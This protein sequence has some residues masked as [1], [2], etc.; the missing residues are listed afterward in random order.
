[1]SL[2]KVSVERLERVMPHP[3]ADR[4]E[5]ASCAGMSFQ[6]VVL[7]GKHEVGDEVL[8]FP[9]D[10]LLPLTTVETLGLT[11][12]LTGQEQNRIKTAKLRGEISQG[13]VEFPEKLLGPSWREIPADELTERLGVTKY[14]AEPISCQN[15]TLLPLPDGVSVYD[16]EGA[17]RFPEVIEELLDQ[18][19]LITEKLEGSHFAL[20]RKVDGTVLVCQ[21]RYSIEPEDGGEH[22][23]WRVA[24][25]QGLIDF[26]ETLTKDYAGQ[27]ITLRGEFIGPKVQKNIYQL[28]KQAVYLFDILVDGRYLDGETYLNVTEGQLRAPILSSDSSL[29]EWLAAKTIQEASNG[30]SVLHKTKREGIVVTPWQEQRRHGLGRLIIKQRSP[31]YLAKTDF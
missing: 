13:L 3:N 1:M 17:D 25:E 6:F 21:R 27:Q 31:D 15:G 10:A 23:F 29:R 2:F 28:K 18:R 9:I 22:D 16:I 8:Y 19:V 20:T 30:R 4:L 5:I 14:E 12:R 11:G 24:R 26:V 7:K